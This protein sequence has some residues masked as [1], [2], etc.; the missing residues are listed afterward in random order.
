MWKAGAEQIPKP[1]VR[2][3][4]PSPAP[5]GERPGGSDFRNLTRPGHGGPRTRTAPRSARF[6]WHANRVLCATVV[7]AAVVRPGELP[8]WCPG[9]TVRSAARPTTQGPPRDHGGRAKGGENWYD[10]RQLFADGGCR[11][12]PPHTGQGWPVP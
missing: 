5:S 1:T 6:A 7:L 10:S 11:T 2:V 4:F 3:R 8:Q 9:V 12:R